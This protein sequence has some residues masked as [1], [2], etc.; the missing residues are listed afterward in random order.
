[1]DEPGQINCIKQIERLEIK[2]LITG[3][4]ETN[5]NKQNLYTKVLRKIAGVR[6][7]KVNLLKKIEEE[8]KK[9][10]NLLN[11][12]DKEAIKNFLTGLDKFLELEKRESSRYFFLIAARETSSESPRTS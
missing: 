3:I 10:N 11:S 4:N 6:A 8:I 1:L 2:E 9:G 7:A 12:D 5:E